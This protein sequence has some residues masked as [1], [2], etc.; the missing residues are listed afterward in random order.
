MPPS[1][2]KPAK[3]EPKID[4]PKKQKKIEKEEKEFRKKFRV[5]HIVCLK[6]PNNHTILIR[7][8]ITL[9]FV[10][11]YLHGTY[12]NTQPTFNAVFLKH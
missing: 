7:L 9:L 4:D 3:P 2:T 8:V 10:A 1:K 5:L 11:W 6:T 12:H